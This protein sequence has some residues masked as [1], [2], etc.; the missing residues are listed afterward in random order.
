MI[1]TVFEVKKEI[2]ANLLSAG[3]PLGTPQDVGR[4]GNASINSIEVPGINTW[5]WSITNR[6]NLPRENTNLEF[7][8]Q[9]ANPWNHPNLCG[10]A[11]HDLSAPSTVG[12]YTATRNDFI[13][14]WSY[15]SRKI[16]LGAE[17]ISRYPKVGVEG[18]GSAFNLVW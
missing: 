7:S 11:E 14:P 6:F 1:G 4:L 10:D 16:T 8:A 2:P 5:N 3:C 9:L 17:S 12:L 13:Q 18:I 15:G